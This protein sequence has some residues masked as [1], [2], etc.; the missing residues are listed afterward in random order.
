VNVS[1][2]GS[3]AKSLE[4]L[5]PR[6]LLP[7]TTSQSVTRMVTWTCL[8]L[9]LFTT[10]YAPSTGWQPRH[11][12]CGS[13]MGS[14]SPCA[15]ELSGQGLNSTMYAQSG[16]RGGAW[17]PQVAKVMIAQIAAILGF[18]L[19]L[20]RTRTA[21]SRRKTGASSCDSVCCVTGG[22]KLNVRQNGASPPCEGCRSQR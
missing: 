5:L 10:H 8:S 20:S 1:A 13:M 3:S 15:S 2:L 14:Q 22:K 9:R 21:R 17:P 4:L 18:M 6:L 7:G 16:N 19:T 12:S 11:A